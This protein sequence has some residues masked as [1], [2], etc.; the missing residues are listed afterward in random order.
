MPTRRNPYADP[1]LAQAFNN[2]AS[3]F[4]P[5]GGADLAGYATAAAKRAEAE[6]LAWLF[7]NSQ[8]PTASARSALTGVQGYGQTPAGFGMTDATNRRGQ[9][10]DASTKLRQTELQQSGETTRTMLAPVGQGQTRFVPPT[11]AGMYGVPQQQIGVIETKPGERVV[12]PGNRVID[13][14]APALTTDQYLAREAEAARRSGLISDQQMA[15][16]ITGKQAGTPVQV[17]GPD[18]KPRFASPGEAMRTGAAPVQD[19]AKRT[20]ATAILPD[21]RT[22]VPAMQGPDGAWYHAQTNERL[23]PDVR[24]VEMAKPQGANEQLGITTAN[25]SDATKRSADITT[26]LNLIDLYENTLRTNP[27]SIGLVGALRGAAQNLVASGSD[28][29]RAYGGSIPAIESAQQELRSNLKRVSGVDFFDPAIPETEFIQ[30]TLAYAIARAENA[31]DNVSN[32]DYANALSRVKGGGLLGNSQSA[33]GAMAGARRALQAQ[34][35]GNQVL[36]NPA[37]GRTD[38][39]AMPVP[40]APSQQPQQPGGVERWT[41]DANGRLVK[42]Q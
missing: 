5:P 4:A 8:D 7:N 26:A 35:S 1:A 41:R 9:D 22:Q 32:V 10:I 27:G 20:N 19:Q 23:P 29:A 33:L 6:R 31:G 15:D 21:G 25:R 12:L 2:I 28:F 30:A 42:V 40:A 39:N 37:A 11:I 13:G 24:V 36:T 14:P 38:A 17:L 16:I 3:M 34:I 18:N